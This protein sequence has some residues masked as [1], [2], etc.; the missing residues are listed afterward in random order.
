MRLEKN[1]V[2]EMSAILIRGQRVTTIPRNMACCIPAVWY[3]SIVP[4]FLK[5][6]A[7]L[8]MMQY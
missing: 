6:R 3:R 8:Q 4:I 1:V 5:L 7:P 2:L